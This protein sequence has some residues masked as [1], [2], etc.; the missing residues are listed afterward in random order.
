MKVF[1]KQMTMLSRTAVAVVIDVDGHEGSYVFNVEDVEDGMLLVIAPD[2]FYA[3]INSDLEKKNKICK[4]VVS[5]L[6]AG[7]ALES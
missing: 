5:L 4:A 2:E 6:V 1:L 3:V 7:H